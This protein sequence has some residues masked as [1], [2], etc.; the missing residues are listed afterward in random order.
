M[1]RAP[2]P[3]VSREGVLLAAGG[4]AILLQLADSAVGRG[5]ARHSD[6]AAHAL[7]R[8]HGTLAY[9]YA[10]AAGTP[11][12]VTAVRRRVDRAHAP[13]RGAGYSAMDPELQLWVAA[14]LYDSAVT[15]I[16]RVLGPLPAADADLMYDRF[17]EL[18]T[19]LQVPAG[20]WPADR[21]AFRDYWDAR[22]ATLAVDDEVRQ[23]AVTLLAPGTLPWWLRPLAPLVR[24]L[25]LGLLPEAVR[26]LYALPWDAADERALGRVLR[27]TAAVYPRLPR[28][29]RFAPERHYL[30]R[31]RRVAATR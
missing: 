16:E 27:V 23:V 13:V 20:R 10:V 9:V 4:R 2:F 14:T 1:T 12:D 18:G 31:V 25:S 11:E 28:W 8:L 7:G 3:E 21:A 6:F 5:V 26:D 19:V 22:V 17:G 15:V 30:R 29:V 24:R